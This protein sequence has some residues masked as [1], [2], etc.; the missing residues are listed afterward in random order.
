MKTAF[1]LLKLIQELYE[2][3]SCYGSD[4]WYECNDWWIKNAIVTKCKKTSY[5]TTMM[6]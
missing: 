3:H 4:L 2:C 1:E 6:S 5:E